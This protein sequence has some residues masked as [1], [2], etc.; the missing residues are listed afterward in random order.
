VIQLR[1]TTCAPVN[2]SKASS[3][4]RVSFSLARRRPP[5]REQLPHPRPRLPRLLLA[6]V[7]AVGRHQRSEVQRRPHSVLRRRPVSAR[8]AHLRSAS[9]QA[10]TTLPAAAR[11]ETRHC[12]SKVGQHPFLRG[13]RL[14]SVSVR[15]HRRH[16]RLLRRRPSSLAAQARRR[17]S[18]LVVRWLSV[19]HLRRHRLLSVP[20]QRRL[21]LRVATLSPWELT[22][23]Q[24]RALQHASSSAPTSDAEGRTHRRAT[25]AG[26]LG[27]SVPCIAVRDDE[28]GAPSRGWDLFPCSRGRGM[29]DLLLKKLVRTRVA[30]VC[31]RISVRRWLR[32]YWCGYGC[33]AVERTPQP[34]RHG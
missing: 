29:A 12:R 8:E 5:R 6:L 7:A 14:S 15:P 30:C 11:S 16:L 25:S 3:D 32:L 20:R 18:N 31:L 9:Q 33:S 2:P 34:S 21:R 22:P 19:P 28:G 1:P 26:L 13:V 24:V 10:R 23:P 27:A 17:T 4:G